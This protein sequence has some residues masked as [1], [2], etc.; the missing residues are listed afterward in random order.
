MTSL[1]HVDF[2]TAVTASAKVE[3]AAVAGEEEDWADRF[4]LRGKRTTM[5]HEDALGAKVVLRA[6][7]GL[8]AADDIN[9][10]ISATPIHPLN[11]ALHTVASRIVQKADTVTMHADEAEGKEFVVRVREA[12]SSSTT[13][14][15][16]VS[17]TAKEATAVLTE[18]EA[19][20]PPSSWEKPSIYT[21]KLPTYALVTCVADTPIFSLETRVLAPA[22]AG[23]AATSINTMLPAP[24][25]SHHAEEPPIYTMK[26]PTYALPNDVGFE[27]SFSRKAVAP[28]TAA[29]TVGSTEPTS[30]Y[31]IWPSPF[32]T[33][34][35]A[36]AASREG[37]RHEYFLYV[38]FSS[39]ALLRPPPPTAVDCTRRAARLRDVD[40]FPT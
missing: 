27:P 39:T 23:S 26:Q 13:A 3:S 10:I 12:E 17:V 18:D 5:K 6:P 11:I 8:I 37:A 36:A 16:A 30:V 24:G 35:V 2:I 4:G 34:G 20:A 22:P 28:A 33:A 38:H 25:L 40:S 19:P 9:N 7:N 21:I 31:E 29:W 14:S 1:N 32:H 15:Y